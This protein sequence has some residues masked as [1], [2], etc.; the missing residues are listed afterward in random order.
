ML[1]AIPEI[2]IE[3]QVSFSQKCIL[4]VA[5]AIIDSQTQIGGN[6]FCLSLSFKSEFDHIS[7]FFHDTQRLN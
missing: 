4:D 2:I 1:Y 7:T 6:F 3:P 5:Q